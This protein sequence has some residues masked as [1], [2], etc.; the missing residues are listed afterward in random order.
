MNKFACQYKIV[1]FAPFVETEEFA[2]VGIVLFCPARSQFEFRLTPTRFGRVTQFFHNMDKSVY[3][4][5]INTLSNEFKR[6]QKLLERKDSEYGKTVFAELTRIK[7]GVINFSDTRVLLTEDINKE[8][9]RLFD[10]FVGRSFNTRDYRETQLEQRLRQT[11]KEMNLDKKYKKE[12]LQTELVQV[13]MPFVHLDQGNTKGAI[14]LLAFDQST[15]NLAVKH[16]D[17]WFNQAEHLINSGTK[18]DDLLFTLDI[19]SADN[20]PLINYLKKFRDRLENIGI[21]TTESEDE[22][23]IIDFALAH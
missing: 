4:T 10:Y 23:S 22:Q 5:I 2:N 21:C 7:G 6:T 9:K 12:S 19:A 15:T 17:L 18:P 1:R 8:V 16:A 11:L 14:K 13:N 3:K 20:E